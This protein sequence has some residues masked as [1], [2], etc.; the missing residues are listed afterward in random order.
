MHLSHSAGP[1]DVP[2]IDATIGDQLARIVERFADHDA[3]VVRHQSYRATYGGENVYPRE[4]EEFLHT[5]P[6]VAGAH[7]VGVPSDRYG[8]EVMAWVRPHAGAA[9]SVRELAA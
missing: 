7:V 2:L 9:L 1:R 4:I 8:E 3:L 5:L 6:A